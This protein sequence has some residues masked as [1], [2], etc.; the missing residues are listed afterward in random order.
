MKHWFSHQGCSKRF[1]FSERESGAVLLELALVTPLFLFIFFGLIDFGRLG[2]SIVMGEK[3]TQMAARIA[4]VRPAVCMGVPLTHSRG[5]VPNGTEPPRFGT[6][7][8]AA[9]SVCSNAGTYSC[10][11]TAGNPTADEIWASVSTL[12]PTNSAIS[13][14][15]FT[16][17]YDSNLGFLGGPY[18]PIVAVEFTDLTFEFISPLAAMAANLG[19]L[20]A[21]S[22]GASFS[23][24]ALNVSLPG[25]DLAQGD[26]G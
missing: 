21:E 4:T 11:G 7:C 8:S 24:P 20:G 9:P 6:S 23:F 18:T 2:F 12:S 17:I 5:I 15:Q 22:L 14:L 10:V 26:A 3:A 25:E 16:Y 13:N 1:A 19:V